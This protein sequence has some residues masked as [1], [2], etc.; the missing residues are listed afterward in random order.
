MKP[1]L[2]SVLAL[3]L[4]ALPGHAEPK[5]GSHTDRHGA[6]YVLKEKGD[7]FVRLNSETG[8]M[9]YCRVVTGNLV[10]ELGEDEREVYLEAIDDLEARL[11]A[12]E[13]RIGRLET[14]LRELG[15]V[16]TPEDREP[17][18]APDATDK[19]VEKENEDES[20]NE[21]GELDD[22]RRFAEEA[23]KRFFDVIQDLRK[24]FGTEKQ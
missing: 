3:V 12:A 14:G 4:L 15:T 24:E 18:A 21:T 6:N 19:S 10:C 20:G 9:S 23:M 16:G 17:N 13:R 2:G 5:A 22:A 11:N 7:G 1:L 8:E